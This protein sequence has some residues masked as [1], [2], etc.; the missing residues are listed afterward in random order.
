MITRRIVWVSIAIVGFLA[1]ITA[2][3]YAISPQ[4]WLARN[5]TAGISDTTPIAWVNG[6]S[7]HRGA[8]EGLALSISDQKGTKPEDAYQEAFNLLVQNTLIKELA[9][10][11]GITTTDQEVDE[12]VQALL[13]NAK[14][15]SSLQAIYIAQAQDFGVAWDSPEFAAFLKQQWSI[16]L[17]VEKWNAKLSEQVDGDTQKYRDEKVR[18]LSEMLSTAQIRLEE[19]ALPEKA[20]ALHI[21]EISELPAAKE[22]QTPIDQVTR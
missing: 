10:Q 12:R 6:Q 14:E 9:A 22:K 5:A 8:L 18:R 7:I 20:K 19:T 13:E 4:D 17:P 3:V 2:V 1:L 16:A 21:P 15:N 11:D